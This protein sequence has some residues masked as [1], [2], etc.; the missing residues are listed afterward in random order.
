MLGYSYGSSWSST[1]W[2]TSIYGGYERTLYDHPEIKIDYDVQVFPQTGSKLSYY[3]GSKLLKLF[4][5]K[6]DQFNLYEMLIHKATIEESSG[7]GT[8]LSKPQ[9][10]MIMSQHGIKLAL[11]NVIHRE[12]ELK[13]LFSNYEKDII[14]SEIKIKIKDDKDCSALEMVTALLE[15]TKILKPYKRWDSISGA[16]EDIPDV[17]FLIPDHGRTRI[18]SPSGDEVLYAKQ[19]A[20]KLDIS[21]DPDRDKINSL[22]AGKM[23]IAKL[24]EAVAGNEHLYY[25]IEEEQKTKPFNIVILCDESGSMGGS[26]LNSQYKLVKVLF[27]AFSKILPPDRISVY[28]HTGDETPEVHVYHDK[29]N[30]TFWETIYGMQRR[31]LQENYDG[32][33]VESVHERIRSMYGDDNILMIII[34]DGQPSGNHNYGGREAMDDLKRIIEKCKRDN[35]VIAGVGFAYDGVKE[36]YHYN[37]VITDFNHLV[38]KVSTLLNKVVK[39]EF[40]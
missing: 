4:L 26:K 13:N 2:E 40:Q 3:L 12:T 39:T 15:K 33:V 25:R 37:T 7:W 9:K 16:G 27:E 18:E 28:G 34:S 10:Y 22:R 38:E 31:D 6:V 29:Y 32:P 30:Q 23:D 8:F 14:T 35:F 5:H 19:L 21:F 17:E 36:L 11:H 20:E 24:A 1:G